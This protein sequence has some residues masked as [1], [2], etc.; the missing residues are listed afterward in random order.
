M[1]Y[2]NYLFIILLIVFTTGCDKEENETLPKKTLTLSGTFE[3]AIQGYSI[4]DFLSNEPYLNFGPQNIQGDEGMGCRVGEDGKFT[5]ELPKGETYNCLILGGKATYI[6][7]SSIDGNFLTIPENAPDEFSLGKLEFTSSLIFVAENP[8]PWLR[9]GIIDTKNN[10]PPVI[11]KITMKKEKKYDDSNNYIGSFLKFKLETSDDLTSNRRLLYLWIL[12]DNSS[13]VSF[14][15]DK[16]L[17]KTFDNGEQT[18]YT[19]A[20]P[21][22]GKVTVVAID[23]LGG[24]SKLSLEF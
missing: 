22:Y 1:K 10:N 3:T 18:V 23:S 5:V 17:T 6:K 14:D 19:D 16:P 20:N 7:F 9:K 15:Y 21:Y 4:Y 11:S 24:D 8:L 2:A 12:E 13:N